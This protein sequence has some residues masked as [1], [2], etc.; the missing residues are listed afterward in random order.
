MEYII[1]TTDTTPLDWNAADNDRILQ[2]IKNLMRTCRYSVGYDRTRGIDPSIVDRPLN[3]AAMLY[4]AEI[5]RV[6]ELYEPRVTVE[7]V[8][9]TEVDDEGNMQFQ[10]VIEI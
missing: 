2:N 4:T 7:K 1:D 10:V 5:Y 6:I 3:E 8:K 9:F